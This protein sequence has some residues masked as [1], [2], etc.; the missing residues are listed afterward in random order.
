MLDYPID[1]PENVRFHYTLAGPGTRLAAWMLD[2]VLVVAL[3][4]VLAMIFGLASAIFGD[5]AT[6]AFAIASFV[7]LSGYWIILELI[8][9]GRTVGKRALSLRVVG[10]RG[11]RLTLGQ[12][13]M[14]NLVR[15]VDML[16]G[17]A[18]TGA[19]CLLLGREHRRL[20]DLVAGT[21]VIRE[22]KVPPPERIRSLVGERRRG[23]PEIKFPG[24]LVRRVPPEERELL[25]DLC[26]RRDALDDSVRHGLFAEVAVHYRLLLGLPQATGLSDEKLVL[27]LTAEIFERLGVR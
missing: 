23:G 2:M 13:V 8:W 18:G 26:M 7:L 14:R 20:G 9:D 25:L 16:P 6:A 22:R 27:L 24:D 1:T 11:L 21:L 12:V 19:L 4:M 17:P 15:F 5:Y 3:F 10:E